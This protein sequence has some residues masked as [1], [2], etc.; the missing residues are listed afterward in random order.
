MTITI[1]RLCLIGFTF[2]Q[3]LLLLRTTTAIEE[4]DLP[5]TTKDGLIGATALIY[6]GI[7]VGLCT[8]NPLIRHT[9]I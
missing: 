5:D 9:N 3:P 7:A 6:F 4:D 2:A 8:S 1:P